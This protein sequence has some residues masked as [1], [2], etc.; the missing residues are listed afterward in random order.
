MAIADVAVPEQAAVVE[1]STEHECCPTKGPGYASPLAAMSGPRETLIYVVALYSGTRIEKPD[2][3]ATIDVDP[4]SPTYSQV[5]HRLPMPNIGDEL[6]HTGWNSCS[7]CYGD[8]WAVRRYLILPGLISGRVYVVDTKT[9]PRSPSM[10]KVIEPEEIL[11]K[12]GLTHTHNSHCLASGEVMISCLGDKEEKGCGY[13]LLD[14]DFN[15]K[16]RWEQPGHSP[17]FNYDFWYQPRHDVMI[18]TSWGAPSAFTQGFIPQH[19]SE[20]LY[21]RYLNVFSWPDGELKQ[22]LDLGD[23][24]LIPLEIRFLHDPDKDTGLVA[25][26]LSSNIVRFF[27][28][29]DGTWS[30]EVVISVKPLEVQ[31][32][33]LPELPGLITDILLSLDDRF[34]YL[35]NWLHGDIRQYDIT[36]IKNPKL[37]GQVWVGGVIKKGSP[38]EA[39][40][41]DGTTWQSDLPEIQGKELRGGPQMLQLSLDGKRLYVTNSLFSQWDKQ[42]YPELLEKGSH[43]LQ[44]DVDTEEGGLKI[45]PDF[46]VDF[47]AEPDGPVLAHELRY[48]GGDCTSEIWI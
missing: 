1:K 20:G 6:H 48:P 12:T 13:L 34:L 10:H 9:N 43:M 40:A 35:G 21:G 41:E 4:N 30:H 36:D 33:A 29:E 44:I 8:P 16:G 28:T 45:N 32:W 46:F 26:A 18:G 25:C 14:S 23:S 39:V 42:F 3:L 7:S 31:N 37:T 17:R 5:I 15:I 27:R 47:G 24:G 11:E 19:V 22:T 2:Y 38:V